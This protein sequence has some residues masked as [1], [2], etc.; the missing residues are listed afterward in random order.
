MNSD[1]IWSLLRNVLVFAGG[2]V[3]SKGWIDN[4]TLLAVVGSIG[5]LFTAGWAIYTHAGATK[6][7]ALAV[8]TGTGTGKDINAVEKTTGVAAVQ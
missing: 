8:A 5:T 6:K 4:E 2:F 3:V 7:Q 1:Q